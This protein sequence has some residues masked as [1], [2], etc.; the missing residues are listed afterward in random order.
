MTSEVFEAPNKPNIKHR[1]H[2]GIIYPE[3]FDKDGLP[4][5]AYTEKYDLNKAYAYVM[6]HMKYVYILDITQQITQT[7]TLDGDGVYFVETH[8]DSL[9]HCTNWYSFEMLEKVLKIGEYFKVKYK[10]NV[11]KI[12][13][14]YPKIFERLEK[15]IT[16]VSVRKKVKNVI[17]GLTGK[18]YSKST[19]V[20]L[21]TSKKR[22]NEI[23][24]NGNEISVYQTT[25]G[26]L[27]L[28][29]DERN[30]VILQ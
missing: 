10:L 26:Y 25:R 12:I 20:R 23:H 2:S 28:R 16:D 30:A 24:S 29:Q 17:S 5:S 19:S 11:K 15:E 21:T 6:K 7:R 22:Y 27:F 3:Y 14:P 13:N 9:S 4:N 1:T 18:T 8:E